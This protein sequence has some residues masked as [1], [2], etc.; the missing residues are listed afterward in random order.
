M[1]RVEDAG[2]GE[3]GRSRLCDLHTLKVVVVPLLEVR[4]HALHRFPIAEH[5]DTVDVLVRLEEVALLRRSLGLIEL[6]LQN[7]RDLCIEQARRVLEICER[8]WKQARL[9]ATQVPGSARRGRRAAAGRAGAGRHPN[10]A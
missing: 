2:G 10:Q 6:I 9:C 5:F 1:G 4:S 3:A 8:E 7:E